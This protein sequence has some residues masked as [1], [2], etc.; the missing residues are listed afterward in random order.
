MTTATKQ[1]P[2]R[3]VTSEGHVYLGDKSQIGATTANGR[4]ARLGQPDARIQSLAD[5]SNIL[6]DLRSRQVDVFGSMTKMTAGVATEMAGDTVLSFEDASQKKFLT[7][8][9]D[10]EKTLCRA[11]TIPGDYFVRLPADMRAQQINYWLNQA[12]D[13]LRGEKRMWRTQDGR[14]RGIVT[15][16]YER[17]WHGQDVV[18]ALQGM[19]NRFAHHATWLSDTRMD[20]ALYDPEL[21]L[22]VDGGPGVGKLYLGFHVTNGETGHVAFNYNVFLFG[23]ICMNYN[24]WNYHNVEEGRTRHFGE[25]AVR[26]ALRNMQTAALRVREAAGEATSMV[27]DAQGD[28]MLDAGQDTEKLIDAIR[29]AGVTKKVAAMAIDKAR[30][31]FGGDVT[32]W[33]LTQGLTFVS[34]A[35][36]IAQRFAVDEVSGKILGKELIRK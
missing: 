8:T 27:K 32:R 36:P 6:R 31:D 11:L 9:L 5:A 19:G 13:G 12:D 20:V 3:E 15:P 21:A 33:S 10:A 22:D 2:V 18:D 4:L 24:I 25:R 29:K 16:G 17:I 7:M 1:G 26:Q 35:L 14:V 23:A 28:V 34:Q 30:M